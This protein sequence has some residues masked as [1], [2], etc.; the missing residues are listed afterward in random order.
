MAYVYEITDVDGDKVWCNKMKDVKCVVKKM[1]N[2]GCPPDVIARYLITL[3][4]NTKELLNFCSGQ[5][6]AH[7]VK[8]LNT[9]TL[10]LE[11]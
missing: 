9:K 5:G 6:F 11:N 10:K 3:P 7:E 2:I 4:K 1:N 8:F